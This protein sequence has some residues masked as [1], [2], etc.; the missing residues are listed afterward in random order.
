MTSPYDYRAMV[1]R[2]QVW[3]WPTPADLAAQKPSRTGPVRIGDTERDRAIATLGDHF[4]AGRLNRE[5]LDERVEAAMQARFDDDLEP[6]F[7][8]LP[9]PEP[10]LEP[11]GVAGE[12]RLRV[13]PLL[14][15]LMPLVLLATV[16]TAVLIGAPWILWGFFWVFLF[17]G[18]WG[19]RRYYPRYHHPG[20][21]R[22]MQR[23]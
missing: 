14:M 4:A 7:A 19:R 22:S 1:P 9:V 16:V 18:L 5:E 8:D 20:P 2:G 6:L 10:V 23:W 15:W 21:P 3:I 13:L 11:V 12:R 17:S